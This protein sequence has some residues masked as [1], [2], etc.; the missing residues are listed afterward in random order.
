M[1]RRLWLYLQL[2]YYYID[3]AMA[4]SRCGCGGPVC[5]IEILEAHLEANRKWKAF[6]KKRIAEIKKELRDR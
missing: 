3:K 4:D 6:A 5:S 2:A 1:C